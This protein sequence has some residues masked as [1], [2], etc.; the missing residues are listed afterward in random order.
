MNELK[1]RMSVCEDINKIPQR[2][3]WLFEIFPHESL[4]PLD[5]FSQKLL[6][7]EILNETFAKRIKERKKEKGKKKKKKEKGRRRKKPLYRFVYMFLL[8]LFTCYCRQVSTTKLFLLLISVFHWWK[9]GGKLKEARVQP[10]ALWPIVRDSPSVLSSPT[11]NNWGWGAASE[12][13]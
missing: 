1:R 11:C 4:N 2:V 9:N 5:S 13:A 3:S 6:N 7:H 8:L 10:T 12:I